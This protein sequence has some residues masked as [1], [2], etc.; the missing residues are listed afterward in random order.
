MTVEWDEEN[1][2]LRALYPRYWIKDFGFDCYD[3]DLNEMINGYNHRTFPQNHRWQ[4]RD[5]NIW[6]RIGLNIFDFK[7]QSTRPLPD[8]IVL[9][10]RKACQTIVSMK[11]QVFRATRNTPFPVGDTIVPGHDRPVYSRNCGRAVL[12]LM[13]HVRISGTPPRHPRRREEEEEDDEGE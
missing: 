3:T 13:D 2:R 7:I 4:D 1:A 9:L 5:G 11:C 6:R 12:V 8:G 10:K